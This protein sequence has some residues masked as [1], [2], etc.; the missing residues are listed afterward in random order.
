MTGE[1]P[2]RYWL[3]TK[4]F[5]TFERTT[6]ALQPSYYEIL[7]VL[8]LLSDQILSKSCKNFNCFITKSLQNLASSWSAYLAINNIIQ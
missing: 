4:V 8:Q 1:N 7:E 5:P 2:K 3:S 6:T